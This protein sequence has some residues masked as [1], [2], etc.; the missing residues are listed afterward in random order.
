MNFDRSL[1]CTY[2]LFEAVFCVFEISTYDIRLIIR[3]KDTSVIILAFRL[4][5]DDSHL[6]IAKV[7]TANSFQKCGK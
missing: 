1:K 2:L 4:S 5:I 3:Y 7:F 6:L